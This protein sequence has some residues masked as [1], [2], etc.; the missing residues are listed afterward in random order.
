MKTTLSKLTRPVR[1][2]MAEIRLAS[3]FLLIL[4]LCAPAAKAASGPGLPIVVNGPAV[5][6]GALTGGGWN[7][8]QSP[9]SGTFAVGP[10]GDVIV[11]N[12]YSANIYQ[13]TQGGTETTLATASN[14]GGS[15]TAV[16]SYGNV[17]VGVYYN[18]NIF[19][20]PY[21][22]STGT[23]AGFTTLP[24]TNCLGGTQDTAACI[25]AP[26]VQFGGY[27][28]LAFDGQGNLFIA[29][30][31]AP[32][33]T[34]TIYECNL[35]CIASAT[36][37]ATLLYTDANSM[38][39]VALD[40]WGN[41]FFSDGNNATGKVTNLN[42]LPLV[43]GTY[44]SKPTVLESYTNKAGYNN[45]ISGVTVSG[46]GTVY[47]ATDGD[48]IFAF[49]NTQ[50]GGPDVAGL[51]QVSTVGGKGITIDRRGNLYQIN[52]NSGD[53]V[54]MIPVNNLAFAASAVSGGTPTTVAA[55]LI[56]NSAACSPTLTITA[57]E[58]GATTNEF[59]ATPGTCGGGLGT[60]NGTWSPAV[61]LTNSVTA[62]TITFTPTKVGNRTA[63]LIVTDTT[64]SAIGAAALSGV[65]QGA[66]ANLDPGVSTSYATGFTSP[67]SIS[68]D[69]AGNLA[70]ADTGANAVYSIP[71][72]TTTPVSVG[73]GF[74]GPEA[75][76]FDAAGNLY[77]ADSGN[78]QIVWIPNVNGKLVPASQTTLIPATMTFNGAALNKPFGL[79]IGPNGVLYISDFGNSRVV[80][81]DTG[82]G[83][84]GVFA[85]GLADPWGVA[86]DSSNN[87]YIANTGD[88]NVLDYSVNGGFTALK[89]KGVTTPWGVAVD[90]SGS[91]LVSDKLTGNIV[92]IPNL[93]GTLAPASAFAIET[94]P[95]SAYGIALDASGDLYTSDATGKAVYAINRMAASINLGTVQDGITNSGTVFVTDAGNE[96]ATLATPAVTQS[97]NTMFT[98]VATSSDGCTDGTQGTPGETCQFTA[99]FAPPVATPN[100]AQTGSA[101]VASNATD[102]PSTVTMTGTSSISSILAQTITGFAPTSPLLAGQQIT[103]TATGGASGNPVVFTIDPASACVTCATITGNALTAV[104]A[105]SVIVDANQAAGTNGGNQYAAAKQ[106]TASI[107]V[108]SATPPSVP[109]LI[110]TQVSW[111]FPLPSGGFTDGQ[112]PQGGSFAVTQD[113][114]IVVG[115][116]Y[117]N[118]VYFVNPQTGAINQSVTFN[119]PG[120][121]TIDSQ[122]NL[123]LAH[124]Y[125]SVIYKVPFVSGAYVTWSDNPTPAPPACTGNDTAECTFATSGQNTKAI[126]FDPSGNFYMVSEPG[127]GTNS[128][129]SGIYECGSTCLPAGTATE[130]YADPYGVSQIAFDP[131]GNLFFTD[132][133]YAVGGASDTGSSGASTTYLQELPYTSGTGF[134]STPTVL[135]TL[136]D[137]SPGGYDNMLASVAVNSSG[138][139]Y[140]GILYNGTFAIPN[141]QSGGPVVADMYAVSPQGAKAFSVG[142]NGNIYV[143][144]NTA[145]ADTVG[146]IAI[147][148]LVAPIAQLDGAATTAPITVVDNAFGCSKTAVL[149]FASSNP[150]FSATAGS[151]CTSI[152]PP[153]GP[154]VSSYAAT[155]S[156]SATKGGPQSGTFSISDTANGGEGTA[157][158]SGVG[159]ETPQTIT[160][161]APSTT[162]VTYAPGLTINLA[163]TGGGSQLPI[164]FTVD[165]SSTGA[166]TI[167]GTT[168]T[169]SQA[170]S[171][172]VDAN[173][174]GGVVGGVY[175]SAAP[176]AQLTITVQQAAE[177]IVFA[178]LTA[179]TYAPGLTVALSATGGAG[180]SPIVFSVD[181]S[182]IGSG[183]VSGNV[184]T[185]TGAGNIVV[186][187]NQAADANYLAA[188]QVQQSLTVN[189]AT[190]AITFL[191]LSVPT[192]VHFIVG[193]ITVPLAATGGGSGNPVTFTVA[194]GPGSIAT[195]SNNLVVSGTGNIVIDAN[196]ATNQNYLAAPQVQETIVIEGPL[197]V[198]S[199]TATTPQTQVV[200]TPLTLAATASSN[201]PVQYASTTTTVCT[202]SGSVVTFVSSGTCTIVMTQPGDNINFAAAAPVTVSF[203]V[204]PTGEV[205]AM[206]LNLSI[207]SL[208]IEPGT[209]GLTQLTITS[210]NNFTGQ[211]A[212]TCSG[213]PAGYSCTFNPTPLTLLEG[214]SATTA[215]SVAGSATSAA[216]QQ[217][218]RP[219][220]PGAMLAIALCS[221]G[222][223]KRRRLFMVLLLAVGFAGLGM[224]SGCISTNKTAT[225]TSTAVTVTA[226]SGSTT[227]STTLTV[228][229]E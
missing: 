82:S 110:A 80:S 180:T 54:S 160:F 172:V 99:T 92:Y 100:G 56:D 81:Y 26:G 35:A 55:S 30:G 77:I 71:V 143:V 137:A 154:S 165:T 203:T 5:Q 38:G 142:P 113:G 42:E 59:T 132:A 148:D 183:T 122:N 216:V 93:S 34:N 188:T 166:G 90:G 18:N 49:P 228:V 141:T 19:K 134:A 157:T 53:V 91:L 116:T 68:V 78:N 170:G 125:N 211:V 65:G 10:N 105:G 140:F 214:G 106:V 208:T 179:V 162:T 76:A 202:V 64:T 103:L 156:F 3:F 61:T 190:Q 66:L 185:V 159:Q 206:N 79:A 62:A 124:L 123:Y 111:I 21:N 109:G 2:I 213:L 187:A 104:S 205:P 149:A 11:G 48:G 227:T 133:N 169:V 1:S 40:P 222:F 207:G 163:A 117:G 74:N 15:A 195:G 25:F 20:I 12:G 198:Q 167:T 152:Y 102:S 24:T 127:S 52:Y 192:P 194:S 181:T 73:T 86:V 23:Y 89:V 108:Q 191:P 175:Y 84:A 146:L 112:N 120:G 130:I 96:T 139:I 17:Y 199:I 9:I 145:G 46:N 75:T 95:M 201:L 220:F 27:A 196:Q 193:G 7:G 138:T 36:G 94:N 126:A 69:A 29:T 219:L 31:T 225:G 114:Q 204:N 44:A 223:R 218:S 14:L 85:T 131:W 221:L 135:E 107:T 155:V 224:L 57:N 121:I 217:N 83:S 47:F 178:P 72:G 182:S 171:I 115:N 158:V 229:V 50:S 60:G 97:T 129:P 174:A 177:T 63:A 33:V 173:Q 151:S 215:L 226:T 98:L 13:I 28:D 58:A 16:D 118:K 150:E 70:V 37:S 161:T 6:L 200:G 8:S 168:L 4:C 184:L 197:P 119:G 153:S 164:T 189:Q 39:A 136:V 87:V 43:S 32:T 209:T 147:D 41:I 144:A 186:D 67:Q 101:T 22:A 51:Y 128:G 45:G 176:Q 212:L 88:G 210:Q